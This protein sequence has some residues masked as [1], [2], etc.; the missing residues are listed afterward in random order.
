MIA[1]FVVDDAA[2]KTVV[3]DDEKRRWLQKP[4]NVYY[5]QIRQKLTVDGTESTK[6]LKFWIQKIFRPPEKKKE[7]RERERER[8]FPIFIF[9]DL[10]KKLLQDESWNETKWYA[11]TSDRS[12]KHQVRV[13]R[14]LTHSD[15]HTQMLHTHA[16]YCSKIWYRNG[17]RMVRSLSW[18]ME[19][20]PSFLPV[21]VSW[22]FECWDTSET[23]TAASE[24]EERCFVIEE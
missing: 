14:D 2:A 4:R 9:K 18:Y 1:A 12:R 21:L 13:V 10:I 11:T 8:D 20:V 15:V 24:L 5:R 23:R 17:K 6:N 19:V 16:G 3:I 7:E 22:R